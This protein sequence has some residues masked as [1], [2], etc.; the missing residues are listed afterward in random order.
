MIVQ[1]ELYRRCEL[2]VALQKNGYQVEIL[3]PDKAVI[4]SSNLHS[5]PK[6]AIAE[7]VGFVDQRSARR[8]AEQHPESV[9]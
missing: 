3:G 7:A 6:S 4:G 1:T 5:D 9:N 8:Y 2:R